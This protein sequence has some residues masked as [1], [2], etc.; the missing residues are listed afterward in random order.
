[1]K[2]FLTYTGKAIYWILYLGLAGASFLFV[3]ETLRVFLNK[4]TDFHIDSAKM[5]AR[6][7]PTFTICFDV[8]LDM[9]A[10]NRCQKDFVQASKLFPHEAQ[11]K[12]E[13]R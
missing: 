7:I 11:H 9:C 5:T 2:E 13:V 12:T 4:K 1:M 10:R 3:Q 8:L 6:D